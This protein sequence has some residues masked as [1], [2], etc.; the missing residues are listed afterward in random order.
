M[1]PQ[2]PPH[3][4]LTLTGARKLFKA[5]LAEAANHLL[6]AAAAA[7]AT[8]FRPPVTLSVRLS[9]CLPACLPLSHSA[10]LSGGVG[11]SR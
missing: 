3:F 8:S 5:Y 11:V 10:T 7:A 9:A 1:K 6:T 4:T 2:P